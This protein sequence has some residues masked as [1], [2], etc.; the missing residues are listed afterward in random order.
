[1]KAGA[2][3]YD[4]DD[5]DPALGVIGAP[6]LALLRAP[7]CQLFS[8]F[9]QKNC[10]K[11]W[12]GRVPERLEHARRLKKIRGTTYEGP[13]RLPDFFFEKFGSFYFVN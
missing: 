4:D 1:M 9:F 5:G 3:C 7:Y 10:Q 8:Y 13:E 2:C 6:L 12:F 11:N